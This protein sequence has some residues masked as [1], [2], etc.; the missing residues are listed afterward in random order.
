MKINHQIK[1]S[2]A[3]VAGMVAATAGRSRVFA[4]RR[5]ILPGLLES[6][7]GDEI[8]EGIAEYRERKQNQAR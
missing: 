5:D 6:E 8:S 3:R 7:A 4:T 1:L 2:R